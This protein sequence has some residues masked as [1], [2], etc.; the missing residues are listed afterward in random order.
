LQR[1]GRDD[2][3]RQSDE[4]DLPPP[5]G[6]DSRRPA[7]QWIDELGEP[8]ELVARAL[9]QDASVSVRVS[10]H[11]DQMIQSGAS[12]DQRSPKLVRRARDPEV[13]VLVA[14]PGKMHL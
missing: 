1:R 2:F 3:V 14:A 7:Q 5:K 4:V 6:G 13:Q 12:S 10:V 11:L 9:Q 8:T